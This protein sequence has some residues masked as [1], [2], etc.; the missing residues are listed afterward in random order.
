M[1]KG[2]AMTR[3]E[4]EVMI[5]ELSK[6]FDVV[7][8]LDEETLETGNIKEESHKRPPPALLSLFCP[9]EY[10]CHKRCRQGDHKSRAYDRHWHAAAILAAIGDHIHRD[11]LKGRNVNDQ[12][13]THFPAGRA[14]WNTSGVHGICPAAF[15]FQLF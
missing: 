12:K 3:Q 13:G 10:H 1:N 11:Q 7:R 14:L 4:S 9:T 15:F 5:K 6:V 2:T 8:L